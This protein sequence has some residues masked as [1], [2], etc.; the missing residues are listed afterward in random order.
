[1]TVNARFLT[2]VPVRL[3]PAALVLLVLL[4]ALLSPGSGLAAAGHRPVIIGYVYGSHGPLDAAA[5]DATRLTH[6]N[7]A[8]ANVVNGL[9]V[10]GSPHDEANLAVLTGLRRQNRQL[11]VLVSVGGWTWSG[12]FSDAALTPE[13]RERFVASAMEFVRRHDLD[14]FDVDWEYPGLPGYGNTHR[15]E[16]REHFTAL[17]IGLRQGLDRA[18]RKGGPRLLL[19]FAAGASPDF[20]E[21]TET[22]ALARVVDYV[23]LMT[24][25][26]RVQGSGPVSGHHANLYPS[27]FDDRRRSVDGEVRAFL[28]AG[29]PPHKLV[30]GVP[31]YGR[32][33]AMATSE[34]HGLYQ[35]G[36][37]P[38]P[39]IDASYT[40]IANELADRNGYARMW[41]ADAQA[42]YLWNAAERIFVSYEDPK[43]LALKCE[44][45]R[46]RGLA[47]AMFWQ[48]GDDQTGALLK[49]LADGLH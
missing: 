1:M 37:A 12:G 29:V 34:R 8:F 35:P 43:S 20:R 30:V 3:A 6:I 32:A 45:I 40:R 16:D 44:Y 13:S 19:T 22:Q 15:P 33:W 28:D 46:K 21:H 27:P 11:R 18:R 5:I 39:G 23:N 48:L 47:G 4:L 10:E 24:Y 49:T 9:V 7:Y 25:D 42:P 31:F 36:V 41:D 2:Q 26:F 38:E 14:G 17:M